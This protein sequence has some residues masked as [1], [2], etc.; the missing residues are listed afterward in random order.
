MDKE[1]NNS[2]NNLEEINDNEKIKPTEDKNENEKTEVIEKNLTE[3]ISGNNGNSA[4]DQITQLKNELALQTEEARKKHDLYIRTL[5]EME[6]IKKRVA[7]EKEEFTQFA[8]ITFIK[9]LLPIID[10]FERALK[11]S[12]DTKDIDSIYKGIELIY[13]R[14]NELLTNEGIQAI[15]CV[16]KPF[17]PQYHQPLLMEKSDEYPENTVIEE[18]Q[19]G[20]I[21]KN[22]LIRPS[23]VKVSN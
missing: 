22:R 12:K 8:N 3:N 17:D 1:V 19:K 16:G 14:L 13:K 5:A 7:R 6:N 2:S 9:K 10:D 21:L 20:Y 4:E 11:N 18:L 15:E 23:L